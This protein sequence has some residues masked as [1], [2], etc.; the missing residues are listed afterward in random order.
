[1]EFLF[2]VVVFVSMAIVA[3]GCCCHA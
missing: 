3:L 2:M 1:M